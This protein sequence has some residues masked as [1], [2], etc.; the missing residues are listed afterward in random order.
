M[1]ELT[2][3]EVMK[4]TTFAAATTLLASD[5]PL[6]R[7]L[8]QSAGHRGISIN[9]GLNSV[10]PSHYDGWSGR[11]KACE[12]DA[13]DMQAIATKAGFQTQLLLTQH[14]TSTAVVS[15]LKNAAQTL[16]S[17]DIL[18]LTYSGH[19]GQVPDT[20]G[21]EDDGQDETLCLYDRM[22]IDD[23]LFSMWSMFAEGTRILMLAD[24]CHRGTL[25]KLYEQLGIASMFRSS[26]LPGSH[27][28]IKASKP[29]KSRSAEGGETDAMS[30]FK[31]PPKAVQDATYQA[32]KSMYDGLQSS[33][34]NG[35]KAI[36][37]SSALLISRMSVFP[38]KF[39]TALRTIVLPFRR[40]GR[41]TWVA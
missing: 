19:G 2:R 30:M 17:G 24:S 33:N 11:L 10:D 8:Q 13:K 29:P 27:A 6:S 3:R 14:A 26:Y 22:F 28:T 16:K 40:P 35:N 15:A 25:L 34:P 18:L 36:V 9:V 4:L 41:P 23:E 12:Q 38:L 7:A 32:H 1:S 31:T 37:K 21:D 39:R 20:N 5:S